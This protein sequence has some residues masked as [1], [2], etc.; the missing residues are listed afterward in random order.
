LIAIGFAKPQGGT[1]GYARYI[2]ICPPDWKYGKSVI[3]MPGAPLPKQPYPLRR[4]ENGVLMALR[5]IKS[6]P[7]LSSTSLIVSAKSLIT[8]GFMTNA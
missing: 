2:A 7:T 8:S 6:H 4:D 5:F 1:G 3:E